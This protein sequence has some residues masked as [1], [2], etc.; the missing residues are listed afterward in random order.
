MKGKYLITTDSWFYAP[1]GKQYK[2]VWGEVSILSDS[3]LE[4]KTNARSANWFAR[5]G[6][7]DKHVVIAGCQI[8]YACKCKNRP[9][10]DSVEDYTTEGGKLAYYNRPCNIYI[11]E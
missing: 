11:A 7:D 6:S 5:V 3:I 2:A 9:N 1:D 8:H 10:T 4:I